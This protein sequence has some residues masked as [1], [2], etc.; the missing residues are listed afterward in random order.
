MKPTLS[1]I[2]PAYNEEKYIGELICSIFCNVINIT[3]EIVVIDNYSTDNTICEAKKYDVSISSVNGN[4]SKLRNYG[5]KMSVGDIIIFL[6]ADMEIT[7]Q[8]GIEFSRKFE[9]FLKNK[10]IVS[11]SIADIYNHQNWIEKNWF[12][13]RIFKNRINYINSGHLIIFRET[14]QLIGGFDES[15]ET[16]ED[17]DLCQR[18]KK[19]GCIIKNNPELK[20]IHKGYPKDIRAFFKRERWHGKGDYN[21]FSKFLSSK[22]AVISMMMLL[23]GF[24]SIVFSL[25]RLDIIPLLIFFSLF[26]LVCT[27][28]AYMKLGKFG[29]VFLINTY[30]YAVY[31]T[32]RGIAFFDTIS[33]RIMDY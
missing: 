31:F 15:L 8:W 20:V 13:P 10:N 6:D 16:G 21:S 26:N 1:F 22:P 27:I 28:S 25:I 12:K 7:T 9:E 3:F 17:Y 32:A 4:I 23:L 2:I 18:A 19:Y 5:A 24:V 33:K 29:Y 30:L 11:G 14:F